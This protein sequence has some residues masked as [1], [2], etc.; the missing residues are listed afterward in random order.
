MAML[1]VAVPPV[2]LDIVRHTIVAG[3]HQLVHD[4]GQAY[5]QA[6]AVLKPDHSILSVHVKD[7]ELPM[8]IIAEESRSTGRELVGQV[9]YL[10][11]VKSKQ[12]VVDPRTDRWANVHTV[13]SREHAAEVVSQVREGGT[14]RRTIRAS[15]A[16]HGLNRSVDLVH[17]GKFL[18]EAMSEISGAFSAGLG[19]VERAT[20]TGRTPVEVGD[21][22]VKRMGLNVTAE[23]VLVSHAAA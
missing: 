11:A 7:L 1:L 19:R 6:T 9:T 20:V 17:L 13:A 12:F 21:G 15:F 8:R 22:Q 2:G 4:L 14:V 5:V 18:D 3:L 23:F 16:L 10:A